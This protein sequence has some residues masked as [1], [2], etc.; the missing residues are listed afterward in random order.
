LVYP[1]R[2]SLGGELAR[3]GQYGEA[4]KVFRDGLERNP[5]NPRSLFGLFKAL[6]AQGKTT[7]ARSIRQRFEDAWKYADVQL[8]MEDL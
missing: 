1:V 6:A 7:S 3:D 2:E 5:A 8:R 4:K